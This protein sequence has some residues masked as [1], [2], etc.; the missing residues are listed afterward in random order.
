[1]QPV[2][3]TATALTRRTARRLMARPSYW[4]TALDHPHEDDDHRGHEQ[5]VNEPTQGVGRHQSQ[6][7][8][9]QQH[10]G[11]GLEHERVPPYRST[12]R[13][14]RAG[15]LRSREGRNH[16]QFRM[17]RAPPLR[18]AR[19]RPVETTPEMDKRNPV[20]KNAHH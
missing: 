8:E 15:S 12:R 5:D 16:A 19:G 4:S 6:R 3:I 18:S 2:A 13:K 17:S 20:V 1:M 10:D 9:E 7:P 11:N 14:G